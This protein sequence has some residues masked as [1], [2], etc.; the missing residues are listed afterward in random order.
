[1]NVTTDTIRL[2]IIDDHQMVRDGIRVM[3]ESKAEV[4]HFEIDE[5]ENG[6]MGVQKILKKPFDIVLCDYQLPGMS[7][8][9]TLKQ[10]RLY[11][12]DMKVLALSNYD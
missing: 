12:K 2:L 8:T 9:Q 3:L 10:I 6:E 11:R 7:G 5:A 4:M 1:M